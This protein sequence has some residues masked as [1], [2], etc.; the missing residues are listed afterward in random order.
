MS[1]SKQRECFHGRCRPSLD[2]VLLFCSRQ[3]NLGDGKHALV[4][5]W[6]TPGRRIFRTHALQYIPCTDAVCICFDVRRPESW[7][8]ARQ[9]ARE[10]RAL[11]PSAL[12]YLVATKIDLLQLEQQEPQQPVRTFEQ[13][14]PESALC[15]LACKH[16]FIRRSLDLQ[17]Y[18]PRAEVAD[19]GAGELAVRRDD[20]AAFASGIGATAVAV[21]ARTGELSPVLQ[22]L[23]GRTSP[24]QPHIH[25]I[26]LVALNPNLHS[27]ALQPSSFARSLA[28]QPR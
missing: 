24:G 2:S 3:V 15:G 28:E 7:A 13:E 10:A 25:A 4:G 22:F 11:E 20:F 16:G 27:L 17:G 19:D 18:C 8:D 1:I 14:A 12:L 26:L 23:H 6:D 5:V 21:S 9:W